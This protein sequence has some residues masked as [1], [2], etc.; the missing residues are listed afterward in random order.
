MY[1]VKMHAMRNLK[2]KYFNTSENLD[3]VQWE[4]GMLSRRT[5]NMN[6][7]HENILLPDALM[8]T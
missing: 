1:Y 7:D 6:S 3:T 5:S 4:Q 8:H 2:H